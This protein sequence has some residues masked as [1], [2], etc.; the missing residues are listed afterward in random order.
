MA[1]GVATETDGERL[2]KYA[3]VI[4][5]NSPAANRLSVLSTLRAFGIY[6]A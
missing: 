3:R 4:V 2:A 1:A 5:K 6:P